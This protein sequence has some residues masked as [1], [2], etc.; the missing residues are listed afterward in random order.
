[1]AACLA[2]ACERSPETPLA[3]GAR[4][5]QRS[6]A[7][8]HA[9]APGRKALLGFKNPPPDLTEPERLSHLSDDEIRRVLREGKGQMPPFGRMLPDEDVSA[10]LV[11]LRSAA[12]NNPGGS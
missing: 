10:L 8:C 3:R 2:L 4:V 12:R 7:S 5:F 6:C 11:Y 9:A 1:C